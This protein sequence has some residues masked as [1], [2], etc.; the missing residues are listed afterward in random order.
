MGRITRLWHMYGEESDD[1]HVH[2][3]TVGPCDWAFNEVPQTEP[4]PWGGRVLQYLGCLSQEPTEADHKRVLGIGEDEPL[5]HL[6]T[7][8]W[9]DD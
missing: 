1:G 8:I 4:N 5:D 7:R 3:V 9:N 6:E 2:V